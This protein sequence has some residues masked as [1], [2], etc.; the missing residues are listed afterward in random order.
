[1][2][3]QLKLTV[4]KNVSDRSHF[5]S[6]IE[7]LF[8]LHQWIAIKHSALLCKLIIY[9]NL[10]CLCEQNSEDDL[11]HFYIYFQGNISPYFLNNKYLLSHQ[12]VSLKCLMKCLIKCVINTSHQNIPSKSVMKIAHKNVSSKCLIKMSHQSVL[13]KCLVKIY[14]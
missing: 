13:S 6:N 7:S 9:I 11:Y 4:S 10:N 3:N 14:H 8:Y 2:K 1:M 5:G 12:I